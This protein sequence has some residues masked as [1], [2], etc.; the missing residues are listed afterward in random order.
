MVVWKIQNKDGKFST[1]GW[2]KWSDVGRIWT[3]YP[4]LHLK[5]LNRRVSHLRYSQPGLAHP[6]EGCS[7]VKYEMKEVER[8]E[9]IC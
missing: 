5:H 2:P 6:Y 9:I 4:T 1:G 8:N 7:V 3:H